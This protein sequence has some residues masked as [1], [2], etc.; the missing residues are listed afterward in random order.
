MDQRGR[1]PARQQGG[2]LAVC[3]VPV[4]A[5]SQSAWH[6]G[7]GYFPISKGA[8]NEPADVAYRGAN[9]LFDVAVK[10]LEATKVTKAAKSLESQ[11][12]SYNDSVK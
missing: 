4:E 2:G 1:A 11:I 8:L 5:K 12:K 6:I 10:Q 7:T 9:P 3:D